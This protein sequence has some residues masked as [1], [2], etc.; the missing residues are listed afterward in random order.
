MS[1]RVRR[2]A[3][4]PGCDRQSHR[5]APGKQNSQNKQH[6]FGR[7]I[8]I[9]TRRVRRRAKIP[10]CDRQSHSDAPGKQDSQNKQYLFC[11]I[12]FCNWYK[13]RQNWCMQNN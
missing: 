4:I 9:C 11:R 8:N 2:R 12:T 5:S 1:R 3:K 6:L 10:G 13:V 7:D